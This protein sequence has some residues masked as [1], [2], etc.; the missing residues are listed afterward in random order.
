MAEVRYLDLHKVKLYSWHGS[1]SGEDIRRYRELIR[2]GSE[3]PPVHVCKIGPNEYT[4]NMYYSNPHIDLDYAILD[5]GHKRARAYYE[6]IMPLPVI[7]DNKAFAV[8]PERR[9]LISEME[10]VD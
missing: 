7:L 8:P 4:L 1:R 6:E 9:V 3:A 2:S 5:G 10:L